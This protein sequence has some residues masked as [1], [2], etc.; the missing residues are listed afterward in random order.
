MA[1][2]ALGLMVV[3]FM[4][5]G[6]TRSGAAAQTR[7]TSSCTPTVVMSCLPATGPAGTSVSRATG[8]G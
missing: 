2:C 1:T 7:G 4:A 3:I 6:H 5:L 8:A